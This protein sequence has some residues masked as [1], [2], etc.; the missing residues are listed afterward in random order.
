MWLC[1]SVCVY[2]KNRSAGKRERGRKRRVWMPTESVFLPLFCSFIDETE[3]RRRNWRDSSSSA[4]LIHFFGKRTDRRVDTSSGQHQRSSSSLLIHW[5]MKQAVVS[6]LLYWNEV[7]RRTEIRSAE[8]ELSSRHENREKRKE[9]H[10]SV[11]FHSS[12]SP[13]LSSQL[14]VITWLTSWQLASHSKTSVSSIHVYHLSS[15][16]HRH[17]CETSSSCIARNT[18]FVSTLS[19]LCLPMVSGQAL[20]TDLMHSCGL[21]Y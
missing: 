8:E 4:P 20:P 12:P 3:K 11:F 15:P 5:I 18:F 13:P 19:Q 9:M 21:Y 1:S 17:A 7:W 2:L 10:V 6:L 14:F 16:L